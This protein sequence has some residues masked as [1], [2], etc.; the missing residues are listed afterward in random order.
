MYEEHDVE[1]KNY[2]GM[3][4]RW[5]SKGVMDVSYGE[6]YAQT[7]GITAYQDTDTMVSDERLVQLAHTIL[8]EAIN[9]GASDIQIVPK[10]DR[11]LVR[12]RLDDR[13]E[14]VR[15]VH[16]GAHLGL[17]AVFQYL[18]GKALGYWAESSID[19]HIPYNYLGQHYDFRMAQSPSQF[20]PLLVLRLLAT[21]SLEGDVGALGLPERIVNTI[22]RVYKYKEGLVLVVGGTGSGKSTTLA[23]GIIEV[24]QLTGYKLNIMTI[25][26]PVEYLI[27]DIVQH[28]VNPLAGYTFVKGLQTMLRQNP[29]QI[30]VG[31]VND[32]ETAG[33]L[34]RA[35]GTGHLVYSTLHANSVLEVHD[36]LRGYGLSERDIMQT[37]RLVIYQTL[38]PK[39]CPHCKKRD[40]V[41]QEEKNW[42]DKHLLNNTEIGIVYKPNLDGCEHCE[43]GYRGRVLLAEMLESNREY[44]HVFEE[45]SQRTLSQDELKRTLLQTEGVNFYPIE[46]D[47]YRRLREGT[48]SLD[49]AYKLISG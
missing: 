1:Y 40:I 2:K 5:D 32:N 9:D 46:F 4:L 29:D 30:L 43:G 38:E 6:A 17:V 23:T 31:E 48:I 11:T 15:E 37:L 45:L 10:K 14:A 42:L 25:E 13:M 34:A 33:V 8:Q 24:N 41:T 44:R 22:R 21:D 19:G 35:A 28:S 36:A 27:E 12:F 47:V 16:S 3:K 39:L 20:G 49:V 7:Q 26:N 18:A